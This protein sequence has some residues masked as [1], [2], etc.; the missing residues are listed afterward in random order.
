MLVRRHKTKAV[1]LP[2]RLLRVKEDFMKELDLIITETMR[3]IVIIQARNAAEAEDMV[4]TDY[5]N[6]CIGV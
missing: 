4:C 2:R 3:R 6:W 5:D 1:W